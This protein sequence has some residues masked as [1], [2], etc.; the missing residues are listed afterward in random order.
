MRRSVRNIPLSKKD[1][2]VACYA[3]DSILPLAAISLRS[4]ALRDI[5]FDFIDGYCDGGWQRLK[6][7]FRADT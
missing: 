6:E 5:C 2:F 3:G 1:W 4:F 7:R